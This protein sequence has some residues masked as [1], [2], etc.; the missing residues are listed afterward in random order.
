[1]HIYSENRLPPPGAYVSLRKMERDPRAEPEWKERVPYVVRHGAPG[2]RLIDQ[3]L[4]PE[5]LLDQR[6]LQLNG[7]YYIMQLLIPALERVFSLVDESVNSWYAEVPRSIKA[8]EYTPSQLSGPLR[9]T[10]ES[11]YLAS[12]CDSCDTAISSSAT[13]RRSPPTSREEKNTDQKKVAAI[14]LCSR[15][16]ASPLQQTGQLLT[17]LKTCE[18]K[19]ANLCRMCL[20]CTQIPPS[21]VTGD[22]ECVAMPCPVLYDRIKARNKLAILRGKAL[23]LNI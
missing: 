10:I 22:I 9:N 4:G 23:G 11:F 21:S 19:Y 12:K 1:M 6:H 18:E 20:N 2:D 3:V 17:R 15:C 16:V 14:L 5:E 13:R 8:I 7:Q